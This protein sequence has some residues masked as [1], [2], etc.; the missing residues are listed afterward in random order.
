MKGLLKEMCSFI[1]I[2]CV[3]VDIVVV[4]RF[5]TV[6]TCHPNQSTAGYPA[7]SRIHTNYLKRIQS[8]RYE[9]KNHRRYEVREF[10]NVLI[11]ILPSPLQSKYEVSSYRKTRS[12][13]RIRYFCNIV[14]LVYFT[15]TTHVLV[16]SQLYPIVLAHRCISYL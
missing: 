9:K 16:V 10:I 4:G 1:N 5:T 15:M 14:L 3:S 6:N 11:C 8:I 2:P 7:L 12:L 13:L